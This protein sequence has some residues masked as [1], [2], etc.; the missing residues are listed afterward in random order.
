MN[1]KDVIIELR[2]VW[3]SPFSFSKEKGLG[4]KEKK[5]KSA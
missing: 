3:K 2:D 1:K 4:E 5:M